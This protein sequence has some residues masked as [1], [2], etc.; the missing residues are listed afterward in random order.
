[1]SLCSGEIVLEYYGIL[2]RI[3]FVAHKNCWRYDL[4]WGVLIFIRAVN[5]RWLYR[6][7]S[8]LIMRPQN[9]AFLK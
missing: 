6:M 4:K 1:M 7:P 2:K 9:D 8:E 5:Y 3:W